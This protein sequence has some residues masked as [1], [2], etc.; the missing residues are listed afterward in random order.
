M[1]V[2]GNKRIDQWNE[3]KKPEIDPGINENSNLTKVDSPLNGMA[4]GQM[5]W[6]KWLPYEKKKVKFCP[7]HIIAK[8]IFQIDSYL[9]V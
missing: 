4:Q 3:I 6:Q 7:L 9:N 8:I 1:V 5:M 2:H